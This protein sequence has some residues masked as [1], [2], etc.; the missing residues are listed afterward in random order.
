MK[1]KQTTNPN[2]KETNLKGTKNPTQRTPKN[3]SSQQLLIVQLMRQFS[4]SW[5]KPFLRGKKVR[6]QVKQKIVFTS[7]LLCSSTFAVYLIGVRLRHFEKPVNC[8]S[9]VHAG[10][11]A[12][13]SMSLTS[14][15]IVL[16]LWST[17]AFLQCQNLLRKLM[18]QILVCRLTL[19]S[20]AQLHF[21][22][23]ISLENAM[24]CYKVPNLKWKIENVTSFI[25][26]C[27]WQKI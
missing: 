19:D 24:F 4:L 7:T 11:Y 12:F 8:L 10:V 15:N 20:T 9:C 14:Q 18:F 16:W 13:L 3:S 27:T 26:H 25:Q 22:D 17:A 21:F 1:P 6:D 23:K 5:C 2:N